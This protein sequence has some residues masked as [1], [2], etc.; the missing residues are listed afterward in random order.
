VHLLEVRCDG[1]GGRVK[2]GAAAENVAKV[3]V[4]EAAVGPDENVVEVP[5]PDTEHVGA[6]IGSDGSGHQI[7]ARPYLCACV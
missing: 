1:E 7:L 3:N 2:R 6:H 5:V 4:E